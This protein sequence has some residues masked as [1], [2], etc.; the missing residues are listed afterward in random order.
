MKKHFTSTV[1][2]VSK[3]DGEYK[4]LLHKHKKYGLWIGIGGHIEK[5]E[6]PTEALLR[7]V[8]EETNLKIELLGRD[9]LLKTKG[10]EELVRPV[11]ILQEKIPPF[12]DEKA[13]QHIDLIYF[14]TCRD[15]KKI[16]MGEQYNWFSKKDLKKIDLE[17]EVFYLAGKLFKYV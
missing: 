9:K 1:Y 11:A 6:N 8:L 16:N 7:E 15:S 17:K 5:N 13:H 3:I 10:V 12:K 14:A 2:I 4:I